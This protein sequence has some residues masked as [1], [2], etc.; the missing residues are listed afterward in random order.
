[1]VKFMNI[2][3]NN[4]LHV[5]IALCLSLVLASKSLASCSDTFC[6][7]NVDSESF[8]R[9]S[10]RCS[11]F[12]SVG[13]LLVNGKGTFATEL[14][15]ISFSSAQLVAKDSSGSYCAT[16]SAHT[17]AV[18]EQ[19]KTRHPNLELLLSFEEGYEPQKLLKVVSYKTKPTFNASDENDPPIN[20]IALLK[21]GAIGKEPDCI[22]VPLDLRTYAP[23]EYTAFF[24]V[25]FGS[26]GW[27]GGNAV[28]FTGRRHCVRPYYSPTLSNA[29]QEDLDDF[30][31]TWLFPLGYDVTISDTINAQKRDLQHLEGGFNH[32]MSGGSTFINKYGEVYATAINTA[33]TYLDF[34]PCAFSTASESE[35]VKE[36][37]IR[38][39]LSGKPTPGLNP[40]LGEV[41]VVVPYAAHREFLTNAI[42][43]L[44]PDLSLKEALIEDQK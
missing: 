3:L 26:K 34:I 36:K 40:V 14:P 11:E 27:V 39:R 33:T 22:P 29:M 32:G 24:T 20:D 18:Y 2:I 1:M 21:L 7:P 17:I 42:S 30:A 25:G 13:H 37:L 6:H 31:Q 44:F 41:D 5:F 9:E 15:Y 12:Q 43:E 19:F 4:Y 28:E 38:A 10:Q 35:S 8:H 23:N 16:T